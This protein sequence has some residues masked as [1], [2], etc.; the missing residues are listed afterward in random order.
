MFRSDL[1]QGPTRS[2]QERP[3]SDHLPYEHVKNAQT[4]EV[5]ID[6]MA[7]VGEA[8]QE[9]KYY[10]GDKMPEHP[11]VTAHINPNQGIG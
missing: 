6:L 2:N 5:P 10:M 1:P 7:K 8:L 11:V 3:L 9:M 4:V